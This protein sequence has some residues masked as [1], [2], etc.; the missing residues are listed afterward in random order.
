M[1]RSGWS[2]QGQKQKGWVC[3]MQH[4]LGL[5]LPPGAGAVAAVDVVGCDAVDD[6]L[7]VKIARQ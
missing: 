6:L 3:V 1:G 2:F 5:P 7:S 4:P